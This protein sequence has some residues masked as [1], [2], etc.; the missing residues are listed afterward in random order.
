MQ[1]ASFLHKRLMCVQY[2]HLMFYVKQAGLNRRKLDGQ[3]P[4]R[5]KSSWKAK[6][7][8]LTKVVLTL[9]QKV[10]SFFQWHTKRRSTYVSRMKAATCHSVQMKGREMQV[11]RTHKPTDSFF[12]RFLYRTCVGNYF[13]HIR[14]YMARFYNDSCVNISSKLALK[15]IT[16]LKLNI[17]NFVLVQKV[18]TS[19]AKIIK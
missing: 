14:K 11:C 18:F 3:S 7:L 2:I 8:K 19:T 12:P 4:S 17:W 1:H 16:N 6:R 5:K 13:Y 10:R 9:Y 15:Y